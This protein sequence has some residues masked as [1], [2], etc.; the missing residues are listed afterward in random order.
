M[1]SYN[2]CCE[3]FL[4]Y[5][6][7]ERRLSKCTYNTYRKALK[8]F[9]DY[10]SQ[11]NI[12]QIEQI[13]SSSIQ[14]FIMKL[15]H[16][17]KEVNSINVHI[18]TIKS[19]YKYL[20]LENVVNLDPTISIQTLRRHKKLPGF[21]K[22]DEMDFLL[23]QPSLER[24]TKHEYRDQFVSLRD[25]AIIELLYATGI[26]V[27]ELVGMD[28]DR[29]YPEERAIKVIGKGNKE[30]IVPIGEIAVQAI[31][32]YIEFRNQIAKAGEKALFVNDQGT[33][34]TTRNVS[35]RLKI[36]AETHDFKNRIHPHKLRHTFAT[37]MLQNSHNIRAVQELLGHAQLTSTQIYTHT[38]ILSL[39]KEYDRTH[40]RDRIEQKI[41]SR[42]KDLE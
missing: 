19:L 16:D 24:D 32:E 28:L 12:N 36:Y 35:Y 6:D 9:G 2:E 18:S 7:I 34:T 27:S 33:R 13:K 3:K 1:T 20:I 41:K 40:P 5:V 23:D 11:N 30:R 4:N 17:N 14:Y 15:K 39:S 8:A 10:L 42:N 37:V 29:Y 22:T 38:D 21:F 31:S 25:K 26:R